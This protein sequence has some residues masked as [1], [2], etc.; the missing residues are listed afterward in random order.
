MLQHLKQS[1]ISEIITAAEGR[2]DAEHSPSADVFQEAANVIER[3]GPERKALEN[4]V[5]SLR[6]EARL[7]LMALIWFGHRDSD[8]GDFAAHLAHAKRNSSE[9]DVNYIARRSL[10]LPILLRAGMERLDRG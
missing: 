8:E 5:R 1:E 2:N 6:P 7:E 3:S 4:V 9:D 10:G